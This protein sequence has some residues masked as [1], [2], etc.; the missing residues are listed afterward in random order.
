VTV[1]DEP[2]SAADRIARDA[3][4]RLVVETAARW[5]VPPTVLMG[6]QVRTTHRHEL[7]VLVES[8][9]QPWTP[10][11]VDLAVGLVVYEQS[12]RCPNCRS[13]LHEV[14]AADAEERYLPAAPI[15]CHRCTALSQ[16]QSLS[17][18]D[19]HPGALLHGV[20]IAEH[21]REDHHPDAPDPSP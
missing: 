8:V 15:R 11:D 9:T 21:H 17:N 13:P 18:T 3:E 14:T 4:L 2:Q 19:Y 1:D 5:G 12:M 20:R 7:G 16:S 6:R 10:D